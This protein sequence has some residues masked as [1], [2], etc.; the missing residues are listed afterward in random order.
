[1]DSNRLS[2]NDITKFLETLAKTKEAQLRHI[3]LEKAKKIPTHNSSEFT[4]GIRYYIV[5]WEKNECMMLMG[6]T[7]R[8]LVVDKF[9]PYE[10]WSIYEQSK[11]TIFIDICIEQ[12]IIKSV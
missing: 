8:L 10:Y 1:M 9:L 5:D 7:M 2:I 12:G 4:D 11:H 3:R 6:E